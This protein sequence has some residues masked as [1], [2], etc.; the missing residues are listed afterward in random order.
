M[1]LPL[2]RYDFVA[3]VATV[4]RVVRVHF[5]GEKWWPVKN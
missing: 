3:M 1:A 2:T 4:Q 5:E